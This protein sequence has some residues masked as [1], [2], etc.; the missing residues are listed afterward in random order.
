M[1]LLPVKEKIEENTAFID[2]P[3]CKESLI[4]TIEFFKIV[5]FTP[6]WIGY[7]ASQDENL[8]GACAF[9]GKP[10][11]GSVEI[12]Y[13]TFKKIQTTRHQNRNLQ[14]ISQSIVKDGSNS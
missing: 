12:A 10:I 1:K 2:N 6:P 9:K 8:V 13:G 5:G 11:N 7:Y 14:I 4:Q 3:I